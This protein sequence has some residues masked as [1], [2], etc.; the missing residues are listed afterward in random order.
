[1][2]PGQAKAYRVADNQMATLSQWNDDKLTV[3]LVALQEMGIDLHLTGF[4]ADELLRLLEAGTNEGL[5]DPDAIPEPCR[6]P[7]GY[8][9][10]LEAKLNQ[11]SLPT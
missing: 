6:D 7:D 3:E 11:S 8:L 9:R 2:S 5:T 1:M 10:Q 4:S